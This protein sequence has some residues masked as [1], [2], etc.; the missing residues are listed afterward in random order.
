MSSIRPRLLSPSSVIS[1][2]SS[3]YPGGNLYIS[4]GERRGRSELAPSLDLSWTRAASDCA[5]SRAYPSPPMSGSPPLPPR[6]NPEPSHRDLGSYASSLQDI[7][8]RQAS[9]QQEYQERGMGPPLQPYT[10]RLPQ[11]SYPPYRPQDMTPQFG[12]QQPQQQQ[13]QH[14]QHQVAIQQ[15]IQPIYTAQ[16]A[17]P[18]SPERT[19]MAPQVLSPSKAQRKTKGHVASACVPCKRAH[20]RLVAT[21]CI[22][23]L[24]VS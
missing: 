18:Y 8:P 2:Q 17:L 24:K 11:P 7:I 20:L 22:N 6:S 1:M 13:Q 4:L 21:L 10:E 3:T 14:P 5:Y 12:F 19:R 15:P 9:S 16:A 23:V